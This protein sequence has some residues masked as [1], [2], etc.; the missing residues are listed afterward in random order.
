[1]AITEIFRHISEALSSGDMTTATTLVG[2]AFPCSVIATPRKAWSPT[3]LT[4][5]FVRDHFTDRY[6]GD[7][8]V[9]PGALRAMSVLA[10]SLFPYHR[11]WKQSQTHPAFWSHYPTI[12]HVE[13]LARGGRD[14]DSNIVTTSMLHNAAKANWLLS[15]LGWSVTDTRTET[16]D[17]LMPWFCRVYERKPELRKV[18]YLRHWYVAARQLG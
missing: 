10:P 14:D 2:R 12:D 11:N 9:Y 18:A 17:G 13:P 8:L 4:R 6:F 5:I 7:P 3:S 16:W 15:E 1:M